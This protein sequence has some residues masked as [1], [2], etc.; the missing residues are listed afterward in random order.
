MSH[1]SPA[2]TLPASDSSS[3]YPATTSSSA[4]KVAG[5]AGRP[6]NWT[7]SRQRELARL[8]LYSI[9]PPKDIP[10]ALKDEG[11]QPGLFTYLRASALTDFHRTVSTIKTARDLLNHDPRWLRPKNRKEM[12]DRILALSVCKAQRKMRREHA[13]PPALDIYRTFENG[14]EFLDNSMHNLLSMAAQQHLG[15]MPESTLW[16]NNTHGDFSSGSS[17][18]PPRVTSSGPEPSSVEIF[19]PMEFDMKTVST[20]ISTSSLRKR[21]SQYSTQYVKAIA[22][23]M[24][25]HSISDSS[26]ATTIGPM[27]PIS[28]KTADEATIGTRTVH[29]ASSSNDS[30]TLARPVLANIFLNLDRLIQRQGFCVPGLKSHDSKT[31]WCYVADDAECHMERIWVSREA[32]LK[33]FSPD[34]YFPEWTSFVDQFGNNLLHML[35][36]RDADINA[37][38]LA[39]EQSP[40]TRANA[41]AKT[42]LDNWNGLMRV[43]QQLNKFGI[44]YLEC[45]VFGRNFFHLLTS[46]G[47]LLGQEELQVLKFLRIHL[48]ASRDA[49]GCVP[50]MEQKIPVFSNE[51]YSSQV[52]HQPTLPLLPENA[53]FQDAASEN[54]AVENVSHDATRQEA[55]GAQP[56]HVDSTNRDAPFPSLYVDSHPI[57]TRRPLVER[58]NRASS[59]IRSDSPPP[60]EEA[61]IFKHA[62]LIEIARVAFDAPA[63]EDIEGRNGLQCL[64]EAS[65][66]LSIDS[67]N[68]ASGS[69]HKRKRGQSSSDTS[70][71]R[72]K[73]R[74]ELVKNVV[75]AGVD[76][77]NYDKQ[78]NT[79]L[80]A[81]VTFMHDGED[82]KILS[83][84]L[85]HL[86]RSGANLHWR[87]RQGETAL[88]IA[89]RLGRKVATQVLLESG[90]NVHART[91]E[92]K[93]VLAI[94]EMNYFAAK[95][96]QPLYASIHACMTL[97]V[98]RRAKAAPTLVDEWRGEGVVDKYAIESWQSSVV[99]GL[100]A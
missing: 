40:T 21:L 36:T 55:M 86:I 70:S 87:N 51:K 50:W 62:R 32:L 91:L 25:A 24:K 48:P 6:N 75:A 46:R 45:D 67:G 83:K 14:N 59:L 19:P 9:L 33:S 20:H 13:A 89:V 65:L 5:K 88:H 97:A 4:G 92:G 66:S 7:P 41:N 78:G 52:I 49:F 77:N 93:G 100:M 47:I 99:S 72:L 27:Y 22:R 68:I 37:I 10:K 85:H 53:I 16:P 29:S 60:E 11:W 17:V 31:C 81:F 23:L 39:L 56:E 98:K 82:D 61:F 63:V 76:L 84:L 1:S 2:S 58:S 69:S 64:A 94:G 3:L 79:V 34:Y 18:S 26:A 12:D 74:Y 57:S 95:D 80:M 42:L 43:L 38:V 8:Y 30:Q 15:S 73:L 44:K 35:A 90:A 54:N 96:D 28:F 71:M